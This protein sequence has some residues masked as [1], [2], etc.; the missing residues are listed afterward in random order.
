[1][2]QACDRIVPDGYI[3][4]LAYMEETGVFLCD[5]GHIGVCY[6]GNP[7]SGADD[8]T[9]DML[10]GAFSLSLPEGSFIQVSLLGMPDIDAPLAYYRARREGGMHHIKSPIAREALTAYYERRSEFL[11][12][13]RFESNLPSIGVKVLDRIVIVSLKIPYKGETPDDK[14]VDLVAESGAKLAE[15]LQT[16]GLYSRRMNADDYLRVAHRLTHPFDPPK[17]DPVREDE[18][19]RTQVFEPGES[20][21]I[22]KDSLE[23]SDGTT[24]QM[25]SV[26]R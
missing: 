3:P 25:L 24:A 14:E 4:V 12:K 21:Q 20:I 2:K 22:N 9:V 8:T 23:F 26:G 5:D 11:S 16:V 6:W 1:M 17:T 18:L 13:S 7:V 10:K 15:S 19:L